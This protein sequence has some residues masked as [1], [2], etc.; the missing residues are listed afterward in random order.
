MTLK[1]KG[2]RKQTRKSS[3]KWWTSKRLSFASDIKWKTLRHN[4]PLF[5]PLYKR[6]PRKVKFYY[7]RKPMKLSKAAEEVASFYAKMLK[8]DYT[9]KALFN[10]NFMMDWQEVMIPRER[11]I[12]T[13]LKKCDFKSMHQ[14]FQKLSEA[15]KKRSK[16]QIEADRKRQQKLVEKYGYCILNGC[17][18]KI[19]NFRIEPPGLFRGRG[20]HPK[21]GRLKKRVRP[22]DVVINIGKNVKT[23]KP[24]VPGKWKDV[25]S[26][27][28][29]TWLAH[30]VDNI[31]SKH[32][33]VFL[34]PSSSIKGKSDFEKYE[35]ARKL[36][37]YIKTIRRK[38]M[39]GMNAK[40]P[41]VQQMSVAL[42]LIDQLALR[43]GNE[44]KKDT[45]DTVG[46]C[47]LRKQHIKLRKKGNKN[48][49]DLK[50]RGKD[51]MLYKRSIPVKKS[52][53]NALKRLTYGKSARIK[54][55]DEISPP[56]VNDYLNSIMHGLSAKVFRTYNSSKLFEKKLQHTK[57]KMSV[58]EK[59]KRYGEANRDVAILCGHTRTPLK[60]HGKR[61]KTLNSKEPT[62][63]LL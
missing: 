28:T 31:S 60:T 39:R 46:C 63:P 48:I 61:T 56:M 58:D 14:H 27:N 16:K 50:F 10:K 17:K 57:A 38:Y 44:K 47:S 12:I 3:S 19:G 25:I 43:I 6:L 37:R 22:E 29:V 5:P 4:G 23:P 8:E 36:S 62:Y 54:I 35:L 40:D 34:N 2:R 59:I 18:Q 49:V 32:K 11:K 21:M 26:D 42:F 52:V 7:K 9:K 45:A 30:W 20:N 41:E 33:Y 1:S 24:S 55:F 51:S 53:F 13:D 15:K